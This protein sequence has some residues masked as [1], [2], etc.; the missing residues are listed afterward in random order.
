MTD[1]LHAPAFPG[2]PPLPTGMART[3]LPGGGAVVV[4][5]GFVVFVAILFGY[6]TSSMSW[7]PW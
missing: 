1:A 6:F 4:A 7:A 2:E 5:V 3:Y